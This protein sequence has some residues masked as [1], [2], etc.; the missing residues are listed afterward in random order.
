MKKNIAATGRKFAKNDDDST[1]FIFYVALSYCL[2]IIPALLGA[3]NNVS[4]LVSLAIS[5]V[6]FTLYDMTAK[7]SAKS[8]VMMFFGILFAIAVPQTLHI[9]L[10]KSS[11]SWLLSALNSLLGSNISSTSISNALTIA[12]LGLVL[13]SLSN[14][15]RKIKK[16][17]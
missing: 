17:Q 4:F 16:N 7:H 6:F 5:G 15:N 2:L 11:L 3:I 1:T 9:N 12:S 14:K 8:G 10:I 13:L